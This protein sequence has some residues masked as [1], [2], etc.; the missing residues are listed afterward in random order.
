MKV[1]IET[2]VDIDAAQYCLIPKIEVWTGDMSSVDSKGSVEIRLGDYR[3]ASG[4]IGVKV[5]KLRI[6]IAIESVQENV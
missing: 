3:L 2:T 1:K 4:L 5:Q 6:T